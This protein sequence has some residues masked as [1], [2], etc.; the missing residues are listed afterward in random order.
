VIAVSLR[1]V[2]VAWIDENPKD[3]IKLYS[4]DGVSSYGP[5]QLFDIIMGLPESNSRRETLWPLAMTLLLL[6]PDIAV[7][8]VHATLSDSRAKNDC[9]ARVRQKVTFLDNVRKC[10]KIDGLAEHSAV[11]MTD[12]AKAVYLL[13]RSEND[14][15]RYVAGSEKELFALIFE[16]TSRIYKHNRDRSRLSQLVFDKLVAVYR[17]NRQEFA[18]IA[19]N[20]AYNPASNTYITF[21]MSRFYREHLTRNN[22]HT[23]GDE[24]EAL[25][26]R[27][28][29]K[30]RRQLE[31]LLKSYSPG[32]PT[33]DRPVR[34]A[35]P[36]D[37]AD[38]IVQMLLNYMENID[39]ALIGTRLDHKLGMNAD[40]KL[41]FDE[42]QIL[43][44]IVEASV[45]SKHE[46]IAKAG[47]DFV[48]L[49][50]SPKNAWR[51]AEYAKMNPEG[52][53]FWQYTYSP[54]LRC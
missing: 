37:K 24:I 34:G 26:P 53:L 41:V 39:A 28:A 9:H 30:M 11:C 54:N 12:Y 35:P 29:P 5:D 7:P 2:I 31:Y 51:W 13:P 16:P 49:I 32:S 42:T 19:V 40:T 52:Q 44:S 27:V 8:A 22:T 17:S 20:K 4:K 38:L 36:V 21:N 18:D 23:H 33:T 47:S 43:E 45:A 3:F 6:C 14:L 10:L 50:Y 48:D 46:D 1:R 15:V 25:Y